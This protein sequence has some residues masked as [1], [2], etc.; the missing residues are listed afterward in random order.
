MRKKSNLR[1]TAEEKWSFVGS[2]D[3]GRRFNEETGIDGQS[4]M[5]KVEPVRKIYDK[6]NKRNSKR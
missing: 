5:L 1:D 3:N 2:S 4:G 6:K